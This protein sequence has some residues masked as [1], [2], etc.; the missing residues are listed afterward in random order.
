MPWTNNKRRA[1]V[2]PV[3]S[4][5]QQDDAASIAEQL[6][7]LRLWRD[8][9][10]RPICVS[11]AFDLLAKAHKVELARQLWSGD[12]MA[13]LHGLR[14]GNLA[15]VEV[16]QSQVSSG[17]DRRASADHLLH[18]QRLIDGALLNL[19]RAQSK[20]NM[21]L[22]SAALSVLAAANQVPREFQTAV[23]FFMSGALATESWVDG[24]MELARPL[25]PP[26]HYETLHGVGVLVM[27]NLSMKMNYGSYMREGGSGELKHMTNWFTSPV[28][29]TAAPATF[30]ADQL[31]SKPFR[32]DRSLSQFCRS[33]YWTSPDIANNRSTRWSKWLRRIQNGTHLARPRLPA[34]W[35]AYKV[36][37][38]PIFDRLQSSY[39]DVA[40]E[41]EVGRK[42]LSDAKIIFAAGDGLTLMRENH[43][44][45]NEPDNYIFSTPII[46]PVQGELH[47]AFHARHCMWRLYKRFLLRCADEIDNQQVKEDPS[48]S[49]LNV[50]RFFQD[51]IVTRAAGEYILELGHDPAAEP[52]DDPDSYL[53]KAAQN[54]NF[55]WLTHYLHD[56][57]FYNLEFIDSVRSHKS[58][59]IDILWREFFASAHT[60]TAHK[61]QYV[62][63]SILRVFWGQ[64]LVGDLDELYHALHVVSANGGV[65]DGV[66][67]DW[68]IELLN[69]AI[70]SHV[71]YHVSEEQ[72][73]NFLRDWPLLE[74]VL[75]Q[76]QEIMYANRAD[77]D[78]RGRDVDADVAT[79]KAFF[80]KAIGSTWAQATRPTT[81][82]KVVR[83][84]ERG[85]KPWDEVRNVMAR[86]DQ[87][88]P[89]AY[90]RN[91]VRRMTPY[92]EWRP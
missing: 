54:I 62:G 74:A 59:T 5:A 48:V 86:R 47:G 57:A 39:E 89:H 76:M 8:Q 6:S 87:D 43:L 79:L 20:F 32:T 63:M 84:T 82:L 56:N 17:Y 45:A 28:P 65:G 22:V 61:T 90:I 55:A 3:E 21:P 16:L 27:D 81:V 25:R 91:Y 60:D 34:P 40:F 36:Y 78:W 49:D 52:W 37:G 2:A 26:C 70:K 53:P 77:R 41:L 23:R 9:L 10:L 83:G 73:V 75:A 88:A 18:K 1:R 19:V 68:A 67:W 64:A 46:I 24:I 92:F 35:K 38:D 33:F 50:T 51:S 58:R 4:E 44:L 72:I 13:S 29:R 85:T 80:R 42:A 69:H 15:L 30:D 71:G 66:G 11:G 31:W 7:E 14:E 12:Y